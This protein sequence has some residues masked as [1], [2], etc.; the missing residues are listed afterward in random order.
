MSFNVSI[1]L[2]PSSHLDEQRQRIH[3][4]RLEALDA[5]LEGRMI[6]IIWHDNIKIPDDLGDQKLQLIQG[7]LLPDASVRANLKRHPSRGVV[8]PS[9]ITQRVIPPF[10]HKF[11]WSSEI[12]LASLDC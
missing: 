1:G 12:F 8:S 6:E 5:S 4:K 9:W 3:D 7:Q 10:W 11:Q 2:D